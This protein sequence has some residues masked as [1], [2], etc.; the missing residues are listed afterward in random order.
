[1]IVKDEE[2]WL[3]KCLGSVRDAVDEMIVVDTGSTDRTIEIARG[4]GATVIETEWVDDFSVVRNVGLEAAQG[5]WILF[6]DADE[7]LELGAAD[8]IRAAIEDSEFEGYMLTV[9][10][11]QGETAQ[12][13]TERTMPSPRLFRNRPEHRFKGA[14]HEQVQFDESKPGS[15]ETLPVR[16]V[17]YGYLDPV[18]E[19]RQ[20][21]ERNQR[22]LADSGWDEEQTLVLEADSL[23]GQ[24]KLDEA[25]GKYLRVY[26]SLADKDPMHLPGIVLKIVHIHKTNG[27]D[28]EA[29]EWAAKGLARW[30]DYT[31]LEYLRAL[32]HLQ[33]KEHERG[34]TSFMACVLVGEAPSAYDT[35]PGV[36][37]WRAFQGLGLCYVGM[38]NNF[39]AARAF[40]QALHMNPR[41]D[42]S[43]GN[44]GEIY[45][46]AGN[47][48]ESVKEEL[49]KSVDVDAPE[50]QAVFNALFSGSD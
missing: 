42:L 37:S 32:T 11:L 3:S 35:Q 15:L 4:M 16:I 26:E 13:A 18:Q 7:E 41:D 22:L 5:E 10:N 30:P 40:N 36:G 46:K 20:K 50:I 39:V 48:P 1:M 9:V 12:T 43:A 33:T 49:S 17:H 31:D 28:E 2:E 8:Q 34:I 44:L 29:L 38:L 47:D 21:G 24:G 14:I 25:L 23:M 19:E 6:L 45:L 27:R